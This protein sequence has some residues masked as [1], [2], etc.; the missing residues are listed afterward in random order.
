MQVSNNAEVSDLEERLVLVL[1]N[2][3]DRAVG[4]HAR[5][6]L[7]RSRN[8]QTDVKVWRDCHAGLPNLQGRVIPAFILSI[9]SSSQS[10][11]QHID[12]RFNN[13]YEFI[14]YS[15]ASGNV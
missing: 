4:L 2:N 13:S 6:V 7:N 3:H 8:T 15:A 12:E 11:R 5:G 9:A 1:V 14:S 10:R